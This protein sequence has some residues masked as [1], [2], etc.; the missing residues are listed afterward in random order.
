[1]SDF[2]S[3]HY[4]VDGASVFSYHNQDVFGGRRQ[5][6]RFPD[7]I[8]AVEQLGEEAGAVLM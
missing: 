8:A 7:T 1:V 6:S 5:Y 3:I 4:A 2:R